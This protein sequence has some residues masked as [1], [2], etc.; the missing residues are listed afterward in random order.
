MAPIRQRLIFFTY[1]NNRI[2]FLDNLEE[3]KY[4]WYFTYFGVE[5]NGTLI[6]SWLMSVDGT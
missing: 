5:R 6:G 1:V 3:I 4:F 2:W